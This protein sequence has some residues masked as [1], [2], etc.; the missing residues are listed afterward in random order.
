MMGNGKWDVIILLSP[1]FLFT[2]KLLG[3]TIGSEIREA[4]GDRDTFRVLAAAALVCSVA[5]CLALLILR[6]HRA[7]TLK[8]LPCPSNTIQQ[9]TKHGIDNQAWVGGTE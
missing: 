9:T 3:T 4:L 1:F 8:L 7:K 6:R 5:Y 2:G